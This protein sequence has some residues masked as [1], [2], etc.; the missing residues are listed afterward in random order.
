MKTT[1]SIIIAVVIII[2]GYLLLKN[3]SPKEAVSTTETSATSTQT[4]TGKKMAF[5]QFMKQGGSYKCT[6]NQYL[7]DI[8]GASTQGTTYINDGMVRAEY[9]STVQ[10]IKIDTSLIVRDGY[11]YTWSSMMPNSGFKMK[12]VANDKPDTNV[13]ASGSY[14]FNA[15]QIGDYN[16]EAWK[17]DASLFVVPTNITFKEM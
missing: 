3:N 8:G 14:S 4:P 16:C 6:V 7:G 1:I 17:A 12:A 9:S 13:S 10:N 11:T 15:D 5:S 2:G